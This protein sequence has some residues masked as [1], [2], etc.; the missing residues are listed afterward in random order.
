MCDDPDI[1]LIFRTRISALLDSQF[2]DLFE[3]SSCATLR[4]TIGSVIS[5]W[6]LGGEDC[7]PLSQSDHHFVSSCYNPLIRITLLSIE[8]RVSKSQYLDLC[9][10]ISARCARWF[11]DDPACLWAYSPYLRVEE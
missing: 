5:Q 11:L 6:I 8:S 4:Y 1:D 2:S 9:N 7:V 3:I 10:T